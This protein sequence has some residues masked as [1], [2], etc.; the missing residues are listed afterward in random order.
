[1]S[2]SGNAGFT[3]LYHEKIWASDCSFAD[4]EMTNYIGFIYYSILT[5]AN[6]FKHC[7]Q[8]Y[9]A[10]AHV[11]PKDINNLIITIPEEHTLDLFTQFT[12][13]ILNQQ[14][15]LEIKTRLARE[16]RDRLLPK[17]MSG[18]VEIE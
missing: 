2:A 9:T 12:N 13:N 15:N 6:G 4:S 18:E 10:Q 8:R 14:N 16:A 1:M 7:H 5:L 11:T 17:L 3:K